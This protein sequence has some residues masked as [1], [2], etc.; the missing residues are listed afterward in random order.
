[1]KK[2][3]QHLAENP[4]VF[5]ILRRII[6]ADYISL[7]RVIRKEFS[8]V[9]ENKNI[10]S[11]ERI[12]DVPCGTGE[13]SM[14]FEPGGYFGLDISERYIDYAQKKYKRRFFCRDA[15]QSGFDKNYFDKIL[16]IGF[17]HHL[18]DSSVDSVL[19]EAKRILKPD[20][21]LLLIEDAPTRTRWNIVGRVLQRFDIGS[22]I[23]SG[24]EYKRVL[25]KEFS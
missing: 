8:L 13:F 18:D 6:E 22:K 21:L 20:G 12:L 1:M 3:I 24:D 2:V 7:K 19:K 5:N 15:R 10:I 11:G 23:R 25:E 17:F 4:T 14:L 9:H 16:I